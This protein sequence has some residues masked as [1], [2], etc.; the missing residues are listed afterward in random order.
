MLT[1]QQIAK[2]K[3]LFG[4]DAFKNYTFQI[5]KGRFGRVITFESIRMVQKDTQ[6]TILKQ[7]KKVKKVRMK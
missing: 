3:K 7:S 1:H 6:S 2:I 4:D 5:Q